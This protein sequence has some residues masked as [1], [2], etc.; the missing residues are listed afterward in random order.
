MV[1]MKWLA[2]GS[3]LA[4]MIAGAGCTSSGDDHDGFSSQEW[5]AIQDMQPLGKAM[6]PNPYNHM[7]T[8]VRLVALGQ[9]L[10][11]D[12]G[13]ADPITVDGHPNGKKGEA[14]KLS[15]AQCHDPKAYYVDS[16]ID[17][18]TN[19]RYAT[20]FSLRAPGARATP[21][22]LN[23]GYY[24]WIGW[25]GRH[26]SLIMH[27]AGVA[28]FVSSQLTLLHYI[29]DHYKDEY[30]AIYSDTPL[31]EALN[32]DAP[33]KARFPAG[34]LRP[35]AVTDPPTPDGKF[36]MMT[37]ED[38][39]YVYRF[40]YTMA[41]V[42]DTYPRALVT[43]G[44]AFEKYVKDGDVAALS[45]EA[46]RGLKVFIGK[47]AC[48]DCHTGPTLTDNIFHNI[49]VPQPQG[50]MADKGRMTDLAGTLTN[51]YNGASIY[52]DDREAGMKKL[53]SLPPITE[54]MNGVFRTPTLLNIAETYPY[55]HTGQ[56]RTLEEVVDH[57]NKGGADTGFAGAKDAKLRPLD[58]TDGE[59]S[60]LV[61]FLK[62]LTG[63]ID[64]DLSKD[65]RTP[66]AQ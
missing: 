22:M 34:P 26:D 33:D 30:N 60:D 50:G 8:D 27:G 18:V 2:R 16:R 53:A 10:F 43:H 55:F 13:F 37:Q 1:R 5:T 63:V 39:D 17:P 44:S 15:C 42:W 52:S 31:P 54:A 19:S 11:F 29:Y 49:G 64:P 57:Y 65:I 24:D 4:A 46:K 66:A 9:K 61:A 23:E 32:A 38:Q 14:G 51:R 59:K 20:S 25:T 41:R 58:L 28:I 21:G 36:E 56:T 6:I 62:T 45:P 12:T 40:M 7:D 47:A 3:A 48:N 35:K